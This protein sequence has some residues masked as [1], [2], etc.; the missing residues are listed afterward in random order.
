MN[1]DPDTI[2]CI[3][4]TNNQLLAS[5]CKSSQGVSQATLE[6]TYT[7]KA[8]AGHILEMG[9][10]GLNPQTIITSPGTDG[11]GSQ[12][13]GEGKFQNGA[14]G[15]GDQLRRCEE[16]TQCKV[17]MCSGSVNGGSLLSSLF[18]IKPLRKPASLRLCAEG[19]SIH[20]SG[21]LAGREVEQFA[22]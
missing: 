4:I 16:N 18:K 22:F 9:S 7:P 15:Y 17:G 1:P 5:T 3:F 21:P 2:I 13:G 14:L 19:V 20:G 8:S 11:D 12:G 10:N 6:V